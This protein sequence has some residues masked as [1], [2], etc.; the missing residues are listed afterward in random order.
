MGVDGDLP[1]ASPMAVHRGCHFLPVDQRFNFISRRH[2]LSTIGFLKR[3]VD[4]DG[5]FF[6]LS[7][8]KLFLIFFS[9][10]T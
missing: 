7:S 6:P 9:G 5:V 4:E 3:F 2:K 8:W 10:G 1:G